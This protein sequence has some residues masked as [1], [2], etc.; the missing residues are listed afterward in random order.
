MYEINRHQLTLSSEIVFPKAF[1][2]ASYFVWNNGVQEV[3]VS[4]FIKRGDIIH[5]NEMYYLRCSC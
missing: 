2:Y 3:R 4:L 5:S 1:P